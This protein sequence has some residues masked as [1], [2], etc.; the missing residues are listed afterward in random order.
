M[1]LLSVWESAQLDLKEKIGPHAYETWFSNL[2]ITEK[3]PETITIETP[4][5]FFKNWI[6]DNYLDLIQQS[7]KK[8][9]SFAIR[10]EFTVNPSPHKQKDQNKFVAQEKESPVDDKHRSTI[11][12]RFSFDNFVV[13]SSNRFAHAACLAVAESPAKAYNPLFI[14]GRV[15]LGKTHLMQAVTNAIHANN[16]R[17]KH[18]YLS[19]ERFTN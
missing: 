9:S 8:S 7:L 12:P 5:D 3:I 11:N 13:G 19:S 1:E 4:D 17:I 14:Y 10:L 18:C 16:P 15:G 2:K 6:I